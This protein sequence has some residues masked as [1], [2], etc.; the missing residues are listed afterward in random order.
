MNY[1]FL[2]INHIYFDMYFHH[3]KNILQKDIKIIFYLHVG[4]ILF[5]IHILAYIKHITII[6]Y[7]YVNYITIC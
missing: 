2:Y 6:F 3:I 7:S 5:L 4:Y 1:L